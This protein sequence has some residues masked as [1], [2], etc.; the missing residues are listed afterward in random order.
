MWDFSQGKNT[1]ENIDN[2]P[3]M[4]KNDI[5][6]SSNYKNNKETNNAVTSDDKTVAIKNTASLY[7]TMEEYNIPDFKIDG[8]KK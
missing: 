5:E 1:N 4:N 7:K 2:Y 3:W 6:M 8:Y